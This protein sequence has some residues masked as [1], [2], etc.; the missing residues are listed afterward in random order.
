MEDVLVVPPEGQLSATAR[1]LLDLAG[2]TPEIVRT[3][4]SGTTFL[5]PEALAELYHQTVATPA[6]APDTSRRGRRRTKE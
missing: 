5:V 6:A 3:T 4:G 1:L 2:D